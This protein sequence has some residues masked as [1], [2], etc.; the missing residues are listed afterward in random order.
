MS[1]KLEKLEFK[2]EKNYWDLKTYRNNVRCFFLLQVLTFFFHIMYLCEGVT[3]VPLN[4]D[5]L[6]LF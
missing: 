4:F 1:H 6:N 5:T 3:H 2:L